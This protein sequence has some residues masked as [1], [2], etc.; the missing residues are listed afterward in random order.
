MRRPSDPYYTERDDGSR[1]PLTPP[2]RGQGSTIET[3]ILDVAVT[4]RNRKKSFVITLTKAEANS[5]ASRGPWPP[6]P[7]DAAL[8]VYDGPQSHGA[9][10][11]PSFF[12]RLLQYL[13]RLEVD[14]ALVCGFWVRFPSTNLRTISRRRERFWG[15]LRL[16][17][18]RFPN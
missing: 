14:P 13:V 15:E 5:F 10:V 7:G 4:D 11:L 16:T 3:V 9:V 6:R 8:E 17:N 1:R 12:A 2:R 18:I